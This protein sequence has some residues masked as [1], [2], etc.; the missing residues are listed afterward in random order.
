MPCNP[1]SVCVVGLESVG[2]TSLL[3]SLTGRWG[4]SEALRGSTLFCEKYHDSETGV[5]F[6]DTPGLI[7][8]S[9]SETTREALR[10]LDTN[11]ICLLTLRAFSATDELTVLQ[12][13]LKG[14]RVVVALTNQDLLSDPPEY[15]KNVLTQWRQSLGVPVTLLNAKNLNEEKR[16]EVREL[17]RHASI[18]A[19]VSASTL[20]P[21]HCRSH[22]SVSPFLDNPYIALTLLFGPTL[23]AVLTANGLADSAQPLVERIV[24]SVSTH[25]VPSSTISNQILFGPYGLVAMLPFLFLYALPTIILFSLLLALYKSTGLLDRLSLAIHPLVSKLGLGGRDAVRIIMGFGCNVP[26]VVSTRACHSCSREHCVS[27]ISFGSACSYQLPPTL[28]VFSAAGRPELGALYILLLLATTSIYLHFTTPRWLQLKGKVLLT[29]ERPILRPPDWRSAAKDVSSSLADFFRMAFPIF[30][31]LCLGAGLLQLL[32]V[33]EC[34]STLL[35]PAMQLFNL[36]PDSATAI[37]LGSIR[38]DG[39]TIGLLDPSL[40]ALKIPSMTSGQLLTCVYLAGMLL[41]CLVTLLTVARELGPH[42]AF[43]LALRQAS[44]ACLFSILIAWLSLLLSGF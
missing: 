39:I 22:P 23:L 19:T 29:E 17:L 14:K 31:T 5:V 9:D 25:Y 18:P 30:I 15:Q 38:K 3:N 27:A 8:Q 12:P 16:S 40:N 36:P 2:K 26:A 21:L 10:A 24:R 13:L 41:P 34:F 11:S 43:R 32:G 28:A 6:I 4:R 35:E 44:W 37:V 1:I 20:P 42:P 33:L 7:K